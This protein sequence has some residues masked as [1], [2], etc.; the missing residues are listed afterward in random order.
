MMTVNDVLHMAKSAGAGVAAQVE[1]YNLVL[2]YDADPP[3]QLVGMLRRFKPELVSALRM[4]Q[5]D[6]R[7]LISQWIADNFTS[8]PAGV[9]AHCGR[10]ERADDTFVTLFV[11]SDRG[12][13]HSSCHSMWLA[14]R[15]A[16]A[17]KVLG[18]EAEPP[19][20]NA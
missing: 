10:G 3:A 17:R 12:E 4:R 9:C 18:L 5:A 6:Q 8:T 2:E 14:Q 15:E 13:V 11:G 1:G 19:S 16:K 7:N 20:K